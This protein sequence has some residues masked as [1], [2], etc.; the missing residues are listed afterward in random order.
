MLSFASLKSM[1]FIQEIKIR[2]TMETEIWKKCA[3]WSLAKPYPS[4]HITANIIKWPFSSRS[5][6]FLP[7]ILSLPH[8]N[9][10][11]DLSWTEKPSI[12]CF[13]P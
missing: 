2:L 5:S 6:F 7:T 9:L 10:L 3:K 11:K 12:L 13:L 1:K 4:L 8:I